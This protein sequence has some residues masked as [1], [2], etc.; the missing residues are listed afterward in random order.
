MTSLYPALFTVF[1]R[2]SSK[3]TNHQYS[4]PGGN[5]YPSFFM[6]PVALLSVEGSNACSFD[7]EDRIG[8]AP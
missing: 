2:S 6:S 8:D 4:K 1:T 3:K 5:E 7:I